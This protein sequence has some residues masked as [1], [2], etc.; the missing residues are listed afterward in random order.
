MTNVKLPAGNPFY[1]YTKPLINN[2][3]PTHKTQLVASL[4][5][6]IIN[7]PRGFFNRKSFCLLTFDVILCHTMCAPI[8]F[9]IAS[10]YVYVWW[11]MANARLPAG[12]PFYPYTEVLI[13][14]K[15]LSAATAC[16]VRRACTDIRGTTTSTML[17]LAFASEWSMW[18]RGGGP[19]TKLVSTTSSSNQKPRHSLCCDPAKSQLAN[20]T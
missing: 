1:P 2:I 19:T 11:H 15:R 13:S 7:L 17:C 16:V 6:C 14:T 12:K 5:L 9:S 20:P 3:S 10:N 4:L 18:R 8:F